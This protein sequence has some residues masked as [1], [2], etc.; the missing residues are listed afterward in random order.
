[1]GGGLGW[2]GWKGEGG[3]EREM[4]NLD[5][6]GEGYPELVAKSSSSPFVVVTLT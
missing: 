5:Q 2:V 1:M 6:R 4:K 3:R